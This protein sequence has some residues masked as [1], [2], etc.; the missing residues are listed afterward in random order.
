MQLK[1]LITNNQVIDLN[2]LTNDKQFVEELQTRLSALGLLQVSDIDGK[3]G[4]IT[5]DALTRF[6]DIVHLN[7]MKTGMFGSSFAK[8]LSEIRAPLVNLP[9]Q[10]LVGNL[11]DALKKALTFTLPHEGGFVNNPVDIGGATNKGITQ[12]TYDAFRIDRNLPTK[13]VELISDQEVYE[14]YFERYWQPSQAALMTLPLAVV[15][16]DTAVLFGVGGAIEFLQE[17]LGITADGAFGPQTKSILEANNSKATAEKIIDGRI[18]Y[19]KNF[20]ARNPSQRIFLD[21]WLNRANNLRDFIA[22]L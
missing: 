3:F 8:K 17:A 7:N 15:H 9:T 19:H 11:P 6:C 16:F 22:G 13:G 5:R 4:P 14:I 10:P 1:D 12:R 2:T 21:G 18:S 20:V